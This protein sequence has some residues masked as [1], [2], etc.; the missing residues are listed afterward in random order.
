MVIVLKLLGESFWKNTAD[1]YIQKSRKHA[2]VIN[3]N[4]YK[5]QPVVDCQRG[6][7][8]MKKGMIA[9]ILSFVMAMGTVGGASAVA[10]ELP[11][12][13]S[14]ELI[15]Q[16][17]SEEPSEIVEQEHSEESSEIVGQEHSEESS[18]IKEQDQS[19]ELPETIE[20]NHSEE[21]SE[22]IGQEY[23][24]ESRKES[25]DNV[26]DER[27]AQAIWTK[28]NSTL[29]FYYGP[30]VSEGDLFREETV[31]NSWSGE[32]VTNTGNKNP[33]WNEVVSSDVTS[34]VV[35]QSFSEVKPTS[36]CS[37]F[38]G[39]VN[40]T[41]FD[42][43]N[44]DTS[45]VTTMASTFYS[46]RRL[47]ELDVSG[48]D[49]S[50]VTNM[51]GM[52]TLCLSLTSLNVSG[53]DTSSVKTM[54][55]IFS[56]CSSLTSL[57][58]SGFD[59]S[60]VSDMSEMFSYCSS[61]T[62]LD[63]S[64][65]DMSNVTNISAMFMGCDNLQ[66]LDLS[67]LD[68][69]KVLNARLAFKDCPKLVSLD[70]S[71]IN[72][73]ALLSYFQM[74]EG[75]SNLER[76]Y[77]ED[78]T[79]CWDPKGG[80]VLSVELPVF[81]GCNALVG[82]DGDVQVP[83]RGNDNASQAKAA[84]LGGYFTPKT[85]LIE[86]MF[87][88]LDNALLLGK[89]VTASATFKT[90]DLSVDLDA[91]IEKTVWSIEDP[92]YATVEKTGENGEN[93]VSLSIRTKR[94]GKTRLIATLSNGTHCYK[95]IKIEPEMSV[96]VGAK[97][98]NGSIDEID[99]I[100]S[101]TDVWCQVSLKGFDADKEYLQS[102][103]NQIIYEDDNVKPYVDVI[104][105]T[106]V[107]SD[108][109]MSAWYRLRITAKKIDEIHKLQFVFKSPGSLIAKSKEVEIR[110]DLITT[111]NY[112]AH[113]ERWENEDGS[114]RDGQHSF[115]FRDSYFYE[116]S[117][118]YHND[119]AVMSLGLEVT[120]FSSHDF[121]NMYT[122]TVPLENGRNKNLKH[123]FKTLGFKD[124]FFFKYDSPLSDS[125]NYAAF[126][127]AKKTVGN[128]KNSDTLIAVAIRG[129]GYGAEWT[130]NFDIGT[131][132]DAMGFK[133]AASYVLTELVTY[134]ND[135]KESGNYTG[136]IKVWIVGF[137]RGAATANIL[138][139]K[140]NQG[141]LGIE[142]ACEN[143]Y[144][145]TF[146]TPNGQKGSDYNDTNIF[147]IVSTS[148]IVPRLA[149]HDGWGFS[150]YGQTKGIKGY[151][152]ENDVK[153]SF[154]NYTGDDMKIIDASD[155]ISDVVRLLHKLVPSRD[156]YV[157]MAEESIMKSYR[158]GYATEEKGANIV[159]C[160]IGG[161]IKSKAIQ[162]KVMAGVDFINSWEAGDYFIAVLQ[163]GKR[164]I[165]PV[166][167][168]IN[169]RQVLSTIVEH[170]SLISC[171]QSHYPEHYLAWL[172]SGG[173][174]EMDDDTYASLSDDEREKIEK[175]ICKQFNKVAKKQISV[176][177]PVDVT[178]YSSSGEIVGKI[179]DN[180][181]V[182]NEIPCF[183]NGETKVIYILA[184]DNYHLELTGTGYG[185]MDYTVKE[186]S[187]EYDLKRVVKFTGIDLSPGIEYEFNVS[188]DTGNPNETYAATDGT[189]T[190]VPSIDTE[191]EIEEEHYTLTVNG[192]EADFDRP[193][194]GEG[195]AISANVP[196]NDSFAKWVSEDPE[197]YFDDPENENT[198]VRIPARDTTVTAHFASEHQW[199]EEYTV[200]LEPTQTENGLKSIHCSI[201]GQIKEGSQIEIPAGE[202]SV[203][204]ASGTCG[205]DLIWTFDS[206]GTLTI[207]GTGD[208]YDYDNSDNK[209]PWRKTKIM[210][211]LKSV[212]IK[213][214]VTK[215]GDNAFTGC[216][217]LEKVTIPEGVTYIG[218]HAFSRCNG[219]ENIRIP[220]SVEN[221][222]NIAFDSCTSLKDIT[223]DSE[224]TS[225]Y[226][227]D[228]V[229][230]DKNRM[231]LK[232]CPAG[233]EGLY[234]VPDDVTLIGNYAFRG[235]SRLT[236]ISIP[237]GVS[238]IGGKTFDNCTGLTSIVI[239]SSVTSIGYLA[240]YNC[241]NLSVIYFIGTEEEWNSI[242]NQTP[243]LF[244]NVRKIFV[245]DPKSLSYAEVTKIP[246]QEYI[247]RE[248]KPDFEVHQLCKVLEVEKDYTV[249]YF[250]NVNPGTAT[251][252]ISG[253]GEY[254][255]S[256][257]ASFTIE[258]KSVSLLEISGIS[259]K[260]YTG[261]AQTQEIVVKDGD[262]ILTED[263][264]YDVSYVN[265]I[266]IGTA[267]IVITGKG[268][269]TD[270][271]TKT[272]TIKKAPNTIT[273]KSFTKTYSTKAQTF[274][275]GVKV[276]NGTPTYKSSTK[277]V[278]VSKTGKV[279]VKAKYMGKATIKI[280]SPANA[281]YT[282]TT[283]KITITVN[284]TKTA[285]VSVASP[286]AG[287][288]TVKWK[289]NA[290]GTG[291]QI[292]YSTSSKF[293]NPKSATI[294]KNTTLTKTIGSLAKGKKYY[295]RIRT[296][297]TV[298]KT[299][300]YSGWSAAKTVTIK[301]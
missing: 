264:D 104:N 237:V 272:F 246:N 198:M 217:G 231:S 252:K 271:V 90:K 263:T 145:Y 150:K 277:Y 144:A 20:Q 284:P 278:T 280:T 143:L 15:E 49:T 276:K 19:E 255:G 106:R 163:L 41:A 245:D 174:R 18:G 281:N 267:S 123:A 248:I 177:C 294:T 114:M 171:M 254:T 206:K 214:G 233:K 9:L 289:K 266:N 238:K 176:Y 130:S 45:E 210:T 260:T 219:L 175:A 62:S 274:S 16:D 170:A 161:I 187:E 190:A 21:A 4:R 63:V 166:W 213:N 6:N 185:K 113:G 256:V 200:D 285:L 116:D 173:I 67:K 52:F 249:S 270:S 88:G 220:S 192:G 134:I 288:M 8:F 58:V 59:T 299:K 169:V 76:I 243:S 162:G 295:V 155:D 164:I 227:V 205:D 211:A 1:I 196:E 158:E 250:D 261:K 100:I 209:A 7:S 112:S 241:S 89:S 11:S 168:G 109:G 107:V 203:V 232:C 60:Q 78:S 215:I 50:K 244:Q 157:T 37:W 99:Q 80:Y 207:S 283:K 228:G 101:Y 194:S 286:S 42:L 25:A 39:F 197:V 75:C 202:E 251:V 201:C 118:Q 12:E 110:R 93:S 65:L 64:R 189:T 38:R 53:F 292:Q 208:M 48:F 51:T 247:G 84:S 22:T 273:A 298:G 149:L 137:S 235:C 239:P 221:I 234:S 69:S 154:K 275:L 142:I 126:G 83:Y 94:P 96:S 178:V 111:L 180:E 119:L 2:S 259:D 181:V 182:E 120:S 10:A 146:A 240:I 184:G 124:P 81:K 47:T 131:S 138:A 193:M 29:T 147:N 183:V 218:V 236:G 27:I 141:D 103:I 132:G 128:I 72:S 23:S 31:T 262:A 30:E 279:T 115:L 24:E 35:D 28:D 195:V 91:E 242:D 117:T 127:I 135:L 33:L 216:M 265:N 3:C 105:D 56:N 17:Q 77:C 95:E 129:G 61:L 79:T 13:G 159:L 102:F 156:D 68:L 36:M 291:Y 224:N 140:I 212:I 43:S 269:Y 86:I 54:N 268:N 32:D 148:D 287:K 66:E 14:S 44:L 223:V 108:D 225:F 136:K 199:D 172:E 122:S 73:S 297:K 57:D 253:A 85:G 282:A 74:F 229:L 87:S 26:S 34:V 139:H 46:C 71:S 293:T 40:V 188:N 125:T 167:G 186:Y 97:C 179:E 222:S 153:K 204:I 160:L 98:K 257:S 296:Y 82:I 301:K 165:E 121:D 151:L 290:V 230:F 258:P 5:R 133:N 70:L 152:I 300:F 92:T 55:R 226:S 191:R